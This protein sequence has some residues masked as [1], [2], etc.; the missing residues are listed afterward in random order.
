MKIAFVTNICA[1]Y[2]VKTFEA[3]A[4]DFDI[5]FM[6]FSDGA[7]KYWDFRHGVKLGDFP[8]G[9]LRGFRLLG[10]RITPTLIEKLIKGRY[11]VI[12]K[13]ITGRFA[14][15]VTYTI[16]RLRGK[17]FI[18]W[19]NLWYHPDTL[20]HRLS[21][22]AVRWIYRHADA[23][24]VF[25]SHVKDYLQGLGIKGEKIFISTQAVDPDVFGRAVEPEAITQLRGELRLG[26]A[27]VVLFVGRFDPI[28]GLDYLIEGFEAVST[29][30]E[31]RLILI[32]EGKVRSRIEQLVAQKR[33]ADKV[34]F[35][36]Y[37]PNSALYKYYKLATVL[38][39]PSVTLRRVKEVWGLVVNE[40]MNQGCPVIATEAVGAVAGG[41]IQ[42]ERTGLVVPER[43]SAALA[44]ALKRIL[45]DDRLEQRMRVAALEE[46][47]RWTYER[48]VE[49]FR[50]AI[51]YVRNGKILAW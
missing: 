8:G 26:D 40:A 48:Q 34:I 14:L 47:K 37:I 30:I 3:L 21:F 12:I 19:T 27:K 41:L 18:L 28:K 1:H 23:I 20:F 5:E 39:L 42:N 49:G 32:G 13:C 35:L 29:E 31:T 44:G 33:L 36:N 11:D 9:Y 6:F 4:R 10:A 2:R 7:E 22:P 46:I 38:V 17:P 50:Q 16:S 51:Q 24:V 15:P 43:D 45:S 25:G